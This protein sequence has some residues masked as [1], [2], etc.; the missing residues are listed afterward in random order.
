ML[1]G[2]DGLAISHINTFTLFEIIIW[3]FD[4][5]RQFKFSILL[6]GFHLFSYYKGSARS[7]KIRT[8][9][10][11]RNEPWF[12]AN[13]RTKGGSLPNQIQDFIWVPEKKEAKVP[14]FEGTFK[15]S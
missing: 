3:D 13:F 1:C 6:E 4:N 14:K 10:R 2:V 9:P 5:L 15:P 8:K 7:E 11:A 12:C